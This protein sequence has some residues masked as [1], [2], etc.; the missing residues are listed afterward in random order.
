[1]YFN[2]SRANGKETLQIFGWYLGRKMKNYTKLLEK[3][4]YF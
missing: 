2:V 4:I 1:M 3:N